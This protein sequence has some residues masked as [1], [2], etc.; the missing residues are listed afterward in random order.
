MKERKC[1]NCQKIIGYLEESYL[2]IGQ[3]ICKECMIRMEKLFGDTGTNEDDIEVETLIT[4][5]RIEQEEEVQGQISEQ[6][7]QT[8]TEFNKDVESIEDKTSL[9]KDVKP[10]SIYNTLK[11][12]ISKRNRQLKR[13]LNYI[14]SKEAEYSPEESGPHSVT[15]RLETKFVKAKSQE[16]VPIK[17]TENPNEP[18]VR[19]QEEVLI[20]SKYPLDFKKLSAKLKERYCDFKMN[21]KYHELRKE[22][23][24][25]AKYCRV[26]LLD[27]Q[28]PRSYQKKFYNTEVIKEFDKHYTKK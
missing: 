19:V 9:G 1:Q 5:K 8:T 7:K 13:M 2:Y 20:A 3:V 11:K 25:D 15:L 27:P 4:E 26:R 12:L 16:A 14:T 22:L 18:A 21:R 24:S 17:Y 23:E 10:R 28:N 6:E